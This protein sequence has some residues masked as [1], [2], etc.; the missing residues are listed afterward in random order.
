M[1]TITYLVTFNQRP[2]NKQKSRIM[3]LFLIIK[4][5]FKTFYEMLDLK[6]ILKP[7]YF[8]FHAYPVLQFGMS[9]KIKKETYIQTSN[10]L[11]KK[12]NKKS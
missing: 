9:R 2:R 8:Q 5:V 4:N 7:V 12:K 3:S 1:I 11:A 10:S 6:K